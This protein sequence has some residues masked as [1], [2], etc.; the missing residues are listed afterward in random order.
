MAS[1]EFRYSLGT[2]EAR[3]DGSGMV[4]HDLQAQ[5]TLEGENAWAMLRHKTVLLPGIELSELLASGTAGAM[6]EAYKQLIAANLNTQAEP[7]DGWSTAQLQLLLE[8]NEA[9]VAAAAAS[10]DFVVNVLSR[11]FPITFVM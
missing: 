1:Y 6:G 4:A 5:A 10:V 8:G 3:T 2:P 11:T 9:S 7:V